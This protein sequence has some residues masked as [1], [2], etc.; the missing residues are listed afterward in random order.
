MI[1]PVASDEV[2]ELR[3]RS[4]WFAEYDPTSDEALRAHSALLERDPLD[5]AAANRLGIALTRMGH[6]DEAKRVFTKAVDAD[7]STRSR[8]GDC[9]SCP[10]S[11]ETTP[12][13]AGWYRATRSGRNGSNMTPARSVSSS[14]TAT[15][16][17]RLAILAAMAPSRLTYE[18]IE[19]RLGWDR[20]RLRNVIG[21]TRSQDGEAM[22]PYHIC[23]PEPSR[24]GEW[25]AWMD[26]DQAAALSSR[27]SS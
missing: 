11:F 12:S 4:A 19:Q 6:Y 17:G 26:R 18:Q 22:R 7:A 14:T 24:T 25:E 10:G 23:S 3:A 13:V 8:D 16:T 20:G 21:G 27:L 2:D 9:R 15:R 5:R 1:A